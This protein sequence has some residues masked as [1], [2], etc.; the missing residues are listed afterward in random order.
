M[1]EQ[2]HNI[3][4]MYMSSYIDTGIKTCFIIKDYMTTNFI[5]VIL[6]YVPIY[7]FRRRN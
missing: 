2:I 3:E 7:V 4:N 1:K 5:D 6:H